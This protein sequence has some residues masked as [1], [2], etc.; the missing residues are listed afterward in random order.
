MRDAGPGISPTLAAR[1]FEPHVRGE[2]EVPGAGLGLSIA[3][4]IVDAHRGTLA[5]RTDEQGAAFVVT[6]PTEPLPGALI[7]QS[8]TLPGE[9]EV[10]HVA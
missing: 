5:V 9:R 7:A 4:G 3:R 10:D 1:V 6:L 8:W 2:A